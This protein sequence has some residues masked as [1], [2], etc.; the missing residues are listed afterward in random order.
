MLFL[1]GA[2]WRLVTF[3]QRGRGRFR[4][5]VWYQKVPLHQ[6]QSTWIFGRK[7][8]LD[9]PCMLQTQMGRFVQTLKVTIE[10]LSRGTPPVDLMNIGRFDAE[11]GF[12]SPSDA[13][14]AQQVFAANCGPASFAAVCRSL[15]TEVMPFFPHFPQRDWTTVGDMKRA[16]GRAGLAFVECASELPEYGVALL[17]LRVNDRPLHPLFSLAQTHWV[18]VCGNCFYDINWRGWLP[19][20][21][22]AELVLPEFYFGARSVSS[23][24][25]RNAFA[26]QNQ[27]LVRLA[28]G[29]RRTETVKPR[30]FDWDAGEIV[31]WRAYGKE[32]LVGGWDALP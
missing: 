8:A 24:S 20:P 6:H 23:W 30:A 26:L 27:A 3:L 18:G 7:A 21:L 32:T 17:Q 5:E 19:I 9:V 13:E 11:T 15:V 29:F 12:F 28:R 1:F 4:G 2:F 22:W 10:T 14:R 25:V 16:L 31:S